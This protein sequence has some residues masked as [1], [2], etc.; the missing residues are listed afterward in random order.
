MTNYSTSTIVIDN[1]A[2]TIKCGFAGDFAPQQICPSKITR[3][4]INQIN[5]IFYCGDDIFQSPKAKN[6]E[7]S[8]IF[9]NKSNLD[10]KAIEKMYHH[11]L[12]NKM[13]I[14]QDVYH[15]R[16][17]F[18]FAELPFAD[19]KERQKLSELCFESFKFRKIIS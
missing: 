4:H 8:R 6:S 1:G 15:Q 12:Y 11:L 9:L 3:R 18:L 19:P 14:E 16:N 7:I 17:K 13:G 5:D 2:H 10:W